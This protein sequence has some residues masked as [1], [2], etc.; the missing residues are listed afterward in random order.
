M[1]KTT[2]KNEKCIVFPESWFV[3]SNLVL[4]NVKLTLIYVLQL[5]VLQ[6][7]VNFWELSGKMKLPLWS[8]CSLGA[9]EP[10]P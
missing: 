9:V 6:L 7:F 2:V 8:G 1:G 4:G 5:Y 3:N 10:D